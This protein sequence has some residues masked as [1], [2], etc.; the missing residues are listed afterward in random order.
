MT[1]YDSLTT[2]EVAKEALAMLS[3]NDSKLDGSREI[4]QELADRLDMVLDLLSDSMPNEQPETV[5]LDTETTGLHAD[6]G[7]QILEIAIVDDFNIPLVNTLVRP[8]V[9]P[10][11]ETMMIWPEAE[12]IHG[13]RPKD[14]FK[15]ND[16]KEF[17]FPTIEQLWDKIIASI[18]DKR[19]VIY[20]AP[21]DVSF[22]PEIEQAADSVCCCMRDFSRLMGV[23]NFPDNDYKRHKQSFAA[24]Y[25]QYK[26]T[27]NAHR[28]LTDAM[29]CRAIWRYVHDYDGDRQ[30]VDMLR[31]AE[32]DV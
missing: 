31:A 20:N 32:D 30:R 1:K 11:Q 25:V 22:Y 4:V 18:I 3:R 27:G 29:A 23:W 6:Q 12:A 10:G 2:E 21:F 16:K 5:Y 14:V 7:D 24:E 17:I 15:T 28:A 19:V 13:I 9:K 26:W 8:M